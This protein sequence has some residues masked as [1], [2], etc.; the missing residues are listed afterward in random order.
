MSEFFKTLF[1]PYH[2]LWL[3]QKKKSAMQGLLADF[4]QTHFGQL[5]AEMTV[6]MVQ[7]FMSV[8]MAVVHSHRHNKKEESKLID[9]HIDF[10]IVRDTMY[11]YS[12]KVQEKF[13]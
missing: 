1:N 7:D 10:D 3:E 11:K 12:K 5:M 13:F 9:G 2:K 4:A 8:L 6:P